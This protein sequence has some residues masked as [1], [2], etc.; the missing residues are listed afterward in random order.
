MKQETKNTWFRGWC[1]V[2][3]LAAFSAASL[4]LFYFP[5]QPQNLV[6]MTEPGNRCEWTG[7]REVFPLSGWLLGMSYSCMDIKVVSGM[8]PVEVYTDFQMPHLWEEDSVRVWIRQGDY[9]RLQQAKAEGSDERQRIKAYR[10]DVLDPYV[11]W[12][13]YVAQHPHGPG[14]SFALGALAVILSLILLIKKVFYS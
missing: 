1:P 8:P 13:R 2:V 3:L 6:A 14:P 12:Q 4:S 5:R 9:D 11:G 10:M 7:K